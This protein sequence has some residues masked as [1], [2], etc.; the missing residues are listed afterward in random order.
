[1]YLCNDM[2][3]GTSKEVKLKLI[4]FLSD[5]LLNKHV[6]KREKWANQFGGAWKDNRTTEEIIADIR[7][8]R[9]SN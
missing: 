8:A 3:K 6:S 7:N 9:T 2:L 1:M 4:S 5:S